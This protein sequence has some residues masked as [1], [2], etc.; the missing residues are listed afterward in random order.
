MILAHLIFHFGWK[1]GDIATLVVFQVEIQL[2]RSLWRWLDGFRCGTHACMG[3]GWAM[4]ACGPPG[5]A[6]DFFK[7]TGTMTRN[8]TTLWWFW[9]LFAIELPTWS[10]LPV[11]FTSFFL[12]WWLIGG[13]PNNK[14]T[15]INSPWRWLFWARR[16]YMKLPHVMDLFNLCLIP[17]EK[18][19]VI[20]IRNRFFIE[21]YHQ[22]NMFNHF[23]FLEYWIF[24]EP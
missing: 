17:G 6:S 22:F 13:V 16:N 1:N 8:C 12:N 2:K 7:P 9:W 5:G 14:H 15:P 18:K 3:S 11:F 10:S 20:E 19:K 23:R 24:S 4:L 21:E